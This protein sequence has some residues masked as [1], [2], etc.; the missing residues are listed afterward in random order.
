LLN[1]DNFQLKKRVPHLTINLSAIAK[2]YGV[3]KVAEYLIENGL[4]NYLIEIGGE[5]RVKGEKENNQRW[6]LAIE[7]PTPNQRGVQQILQLTDI[8]LATSGDYRNFFEKDGIRF[9]HTLD[10]R[11]GFPIKHKLA[12]VTVL[13]NSTMEADAWATALMVMGAEEGMLFAKT[14]KLKV[15]FI[16]KSEKG[17]EQ[18]ASPALQ[19]MKVMLY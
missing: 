11:T 13:T 12:S 7:T 15:L 6:R 2:G 18:K 17:F 9:S 3:D 1:R 5:V 16:I 10:P 14:H 8:A 19:E 4:E